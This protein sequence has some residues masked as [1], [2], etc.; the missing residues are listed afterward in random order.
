MEAAL[1][2][3]ED[4]GSDAA[5]GADDMSDVSSVVSGLSAYT[6]RSAADTSAT[7]GASSSA[8]PSTIGGRR[9]QRRQRTKVCY[10]AE[11]HRGCEGGGCATEYSSTFCNK[12]KKQ[13][14]EKQPEMERISLFLKHLCSCAYWSF[15]C[16]SEEVGSK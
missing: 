5:G 9:P 15:G 10:Q 4:G 12:S 2:A 1:A 8:A 7:T 6:Q 11:Y 3:R 16:R 14:W 13:P